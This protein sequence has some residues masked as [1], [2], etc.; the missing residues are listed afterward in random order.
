VS[1]A[2][3][4]SGRPVFPWRGTPHRQKKPHSYRRFRRTSEV[5]PVDLGSDRLFSCPEWWDWRLRLVLTRQFNQERSTPKL[6]KWAPRSQAVVCRRCLIACTAL[7]QG[8]FDTKEQRH[9]LLRNPIVSN[10]KITPIEELDHNLYSESKR[11]ET[12]DP[13]DI[14]LGNGEFRALPLSC[15][16]KC[17]IY[18][19]GFR[20]VQTSSAERSMRCRVINVVG[21]R[22]T[23]SSRELRAVAV[24]RQVNVSS[25]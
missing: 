12:R 18:H 6:S 14:G 5:S 4:E 17:Q 20:N 16:Q 15:R 19:G 9:V 23:A 1:G 11:A 7:F 25:S 8:K 24:G 22:D 3:G 21:T 13:Y 2:C 10:T